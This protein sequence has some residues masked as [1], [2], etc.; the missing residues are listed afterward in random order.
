MVRNEEDVLCQVLNHLLDQG[1][2][3]LL[4]ADNLSDDD[5]PDLL[6]R[7]AARDSRV[8]VAR[9]RLDAYHQDDKMT[10]LA[11][12]AS[13]SGADWIVPFDADE[14]WFAQ[15]GTVAEHLRKLGSEPRKIATV[16]AEMH[17]AIPSAGQGAPWDEA[18]L[19]VNA[20]PSALGKVAVRA[21]PTVRIG[22]GNH[23]AA[24]AGERAHGLHIAHVVYRSAG[25]LAQKV[26]KGSLAIS[27]ASNS[28]DVGSHWR[29]L[30]TLTDVEIDRLWVEIQQGAP[31]P[32]IA[33]NVGGPLVRCRPLE[34]HSW[35]PDGS[36][37]TGRGDQS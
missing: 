9:D 3:R 33:L 11:R 10:L 29:D 20:T 31:H 17:D 34:W 16:G 4:V 7:L 37:D 24:R 21:H 12:A 13:R 14:L 22:F 26:R 8:L 27:L 36:L 19:Q 1:I 2:D 18:P 5:T 15:T 25:Q 28:P 23:G 30:A 32:E 6:R 35:D